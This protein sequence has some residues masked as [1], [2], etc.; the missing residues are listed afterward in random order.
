[1]YQYPG[2]MG[3]APGMQVQQPG[4]MYGVPGQPMQQSPNFV[5]QVPSGVPQGVSQGNYAPA[6]QNRMRVRPVASY[7]EA[8]AVPT[9]FMG[10]LLVLTDL[11]HGFIYTK[12]L[13]PNTGSSIFRI[14][15]EVIEPAPQPEQ[16]A[17]PVPVYDPK[18]EIEQ[19]RAELNGIKHELGLDSKEES[20]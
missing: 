6:L 2:Q 1:M 7:D 19:L 11:S 20:K 9:D 16:P 14:Y 12:V 5:P 4:Q 17:A 8:K 13:D 15:R 18:A 3:M 10:D